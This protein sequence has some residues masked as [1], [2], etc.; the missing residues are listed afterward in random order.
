MSAETELRNRLHAAAIEGGRYGMDDD[1]AVD[2]VLHRR[3]TQR[4]NRIS[5]V[6]SVLVIAMVVIAL[7]LLLHGGR[8]GQ[9]AEQL[10]T[11]VLDSPT[12]GSLAGDRAWLDGLLDLEWEYDGDSVPDPDPLD[13]RVVWAGDV[14][15]ARWA[16]VVGEVDGE[17]VGFWYAGRPGAEP[18][19]M[20]RDEPVT[21]FAPGEPVAYTASLL[22][23]PLANY[24]PEEPQPMV[25]VSAPGDAVEV[26]QRILVAADGTMSRDYVPVDTLD[27]VAVTMLEGSTE[28]GVAA[29]YQVVRDGRVVHRASPQSMYSIVLQGPADLPAARPLTGSAPESAVAAALQEALRP[30]GVGL[31]L[32]RA[33]LL[34]AGPIPA[35]TQRAGAVVLAVTTPSGGRVVVAEAAL[36]SVFDAADS[37]DQQRTTS[38]QASPCLVGTLPAEA[39]LGDAALAMRCGVA[40]PGTGTRAGSIVMTGPPTATDAVL[41]A[42]DGA[43]LGGPVLLAGGGAAVVDDP[44]A[45]TVRFV[46]ASGAVLVEAPIAPTPPYDGEPLYGDYGDG[47]AG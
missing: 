5:A 22:G 6:G 44:A 13:R 14:P 23:F 29:S 27:G 11:G 17:T 47:A 24:E 33:E 41:M 15:G 42:A 9:P 40:D 46:D 32:L 19:E 30:L 10:G 31:D 37:G 8:D 45:V 21:A 35:G 38:F 36:G 43:T 18:F 16:L 7:P 34:W 25:V 3:R 2:D 26:S 28:F 1:T 20:T 4:R 39:S 12:R